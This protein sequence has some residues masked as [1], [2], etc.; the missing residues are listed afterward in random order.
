VLEDPREA[1]VI[2]LRP[3]SGNTGSSVEIGDQQPT[4][5]PEVPPGPYVRINEITI[6]ADL[7]VVEYETFEY[8]EQLPGMHVHFYYD[9]VIEEQAGLPGG[10]PWIVYRGPR[11]F[12]GYSV[13][14]RPANASQ[15]CAR[16]A[17]ANHSII[18]NSGNCTYLPESP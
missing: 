5:T 13:A 10:G 15:M 17:N 12:K 11:P 1:P 9:S 6:D 14:S 7:H 18:M 4:S 3:V 2:A 16:V 8:T